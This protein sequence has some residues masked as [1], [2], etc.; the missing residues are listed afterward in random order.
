MNY[1]YNLFKTKNNISI[2]KLKTMYN[3][4]NTITFL[5]NEES[6]LIKY[7]S[8]I[9]NYIKSIKISNKDL[10]KIKILENFSNNSFNKCLL[11]DKNIDLFCKEF[12]YFK[13]IINKNK[14]SI[15]NYLINY[16]KMN[17]IISNK[18]NKNLRYNNHINIK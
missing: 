16:S 5:T 3:I 1:P 15:D 12:I 13:D 18:Y 7:K 8:E 4:F 14:L 6:I 11:N 9:D 17:N 10:G 2:E